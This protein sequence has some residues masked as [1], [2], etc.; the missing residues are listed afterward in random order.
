[1]LNPQY[2]ETLS[3]EPVIGSPGSHSP[4]CFVSGRFVWAPKISQLY[5]QDTI[6]VIMELHWYSTRVLGMKQQSCWGAL[7]FSRGH[8]HDI[9]CLMTN[10]QANRVAIVSSVITKI[11]NPCKYW[12][13]MT[14]PS[15]YMFSVYLYSLLVFYYCPSVVWFSLVSVLFL[16]DSLCSII[17]CWILCLFSVFSVLILELYSRYFDPHNNN[18]PASQ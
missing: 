5:S 12:T 17:R 3:H 15:V 8:K 1:M 11:L 7:W 4:S 18:H 13:V 6:I 10:T 9:W 2:P 14:Q 16:S